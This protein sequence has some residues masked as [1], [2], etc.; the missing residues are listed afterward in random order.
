MLRKI[1]LAFQEVNRRLVTYVGSVCLAF[2]VV[3]LISD[4][5]LRT[6][7]DM[8]IVGQ[9]DLNNIALAW[10]AFTSFSWALIKGSHVRVSVAVDR[11]SPRLQSGCEIL[12]NL[13]GVVLFATVTFLAV[14]YFWESFLIKEVPMSPFAAPIWFAKL[15]LPIGVSLMF[16]AFL[17][18]LIRSLRPTREVGEEKEVMGF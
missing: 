15:A 5:L 18:H 3:L 16:V 14:P 6:F 17:V 11:F 2:M 7:F 8:P 4:S 10:L 1:E 9:I 13:L 12:R